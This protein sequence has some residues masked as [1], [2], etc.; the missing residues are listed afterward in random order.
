ME[1]IEKVE[2]T[3]TSNTS[4]YATAYANY[5]RWAVFELACSGNIDHRNY[6]ESNGKSKLKKYVGKFA[7]ADKAI[8]QITK[9][10]V[11]NKTFNEQIQ[12]YLKIIGK[13]DPTQSTIADCDADENN[14]DSCCDDDFCD[15]NSYGSDEIYDTKQQLFSEFVDFIGLYEIE[16]LH[17]DDRDEF[18]EKFFQLFEPNVN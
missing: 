8:G 10:L 17:G 1:F 16:N 18:E 14:Q 3:N 13:T 12:E 4:S 5:I 15:E 2:N 7:S 6:S 11:E 9:E